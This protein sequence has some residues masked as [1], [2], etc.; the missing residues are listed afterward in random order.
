MFLML[1]TLLNQVQDFSPR[2]S[3]Q[4]RK[5]LPPGTMF[6]RCVDAVLTNRGLEKTRVVELLAAAHVALEA[7][8]LDSVEFGQASAALENTHAYIQD[9]VV[10]AALQE[11]RRLRRQMKLC[12][13][14][15]AIEF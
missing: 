15:T 10:D 9:D 4:S 7:L 3:A 14:R 8:P 12:F 6:M 1:K 5:E 11:L 13:E 2:P